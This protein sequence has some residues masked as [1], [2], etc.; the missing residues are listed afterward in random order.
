MQQNWRDL[1]QRETKHG[2]EKLAMSRERLELQAMRKKLYLSRCS[3]CKI[4]ERSQ[5]I[6][7]LLM[8][9]EGTTNRNQSSAI[10]DLPNLDL[11]Q[12]AYQNYT[13]TN[14]IDDMFDLDMLTELN[15]IKDANMVDSMNQTND[16]ESEFLDAS[17]LMT[18][19]L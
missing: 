9:N 12:M 8:K 2:E 10:D 19:M 13:F 3:L 6:S 17:L 11:D 4:G 5:E 14:Q 1:A 15:K 16:L 18:K 7:D